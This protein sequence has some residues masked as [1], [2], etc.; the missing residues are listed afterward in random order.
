MKSNATLIFSYFGL[1]CISVSSFAPS[2][3]RR[4]T[5]LRPAK[6]TTALASTVADVPV[7]VSAQKEQEE[8]PFDWYKSWYPL[9][10]VEDLDKEKPHQFHLLGM[11]VVVWFDGKP[12]DGTGKFESKKN[13]SKRQC[14]KVVRHKREDD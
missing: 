6:T 4:G 5:S 13:R 14:L 11:P 1:T 9:S 7:E 3:S 12:S 8:Q 2:E 10:V